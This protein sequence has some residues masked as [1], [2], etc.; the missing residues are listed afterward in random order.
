MVFRSPDQVAALTPGNPF[1][2]GADGRPNVP[3]DLL[4]RMK[5]VTNDEAWGVLERGHNYHFQFEGGWYNLHPDR[6]LVG[7]AVTARYVPIRPDLHE[8]VQAGGT[9]EGRS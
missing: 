1:G 6:V 3:A 9:A 2:R 5:L 4:E 8:V 7:R